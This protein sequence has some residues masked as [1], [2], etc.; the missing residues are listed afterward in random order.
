MN[1][2]DTP[3]N[4][5]NGDD[6]PLFPARTFPAV[7]LTPGDPPAPPMVE[8]EADQQTRARLM[9]EAAE[10]EERSKQGVIAAYDQARERAVEINRALVRLVEML[11]SKDK[12]HLAESV[13]SFLLRLKD[14]D[15]GEPL[16]FDALLLG[17]ELGADT[18]TANMLRQLIIEQR[19]LA[20]E[21]ARA[22]ELNALALRHAKTM[23]DAA[24][25]ATDRPDR[26]GGEIVR[27][28]WD[29]LKPKEKDIAIKLQ[30]NNGNMYQTA[31][32]KHNFSA[33]R[34]CRDRLRLLY[35]N[36]QMALPA[37]LLNRNEIE[38]LKRRQ[39]PNPGRTT[40]S[41]D[42]VRTN[43]NDADDLNNF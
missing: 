16:V 36:A 7:Y 1:E 19:R 3:T 40:P 22:N 11:K 21:Q 43:P 23:E 25:D 12:A 14:G 6:A 35:A 27:M 31:D 20:D 32:E 29:P 42:F 28:V 41:G 13:D 4:K 26:V 10:A 2:N 17:A 37:W 34:R 30:A 15:G 8:S 5:Q 18:D 38:E 24:R 9:Q 33:V 39:D